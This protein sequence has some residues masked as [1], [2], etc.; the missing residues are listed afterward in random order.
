MSTL[1]IT[2]AR[3]LLERMRELVGSADSTLF[4]CSLTKRPVPVQ[5]LS[6]SYVETDGSIWF[7]TQG[8]L[9]VR[10]ED[11]HRAQLFYANTRD[12]VYL[13]VSGKG[14]VIPDREVVRQIMD[15]TGTITSKGI[16]QVL[17]CV[18][19]TSAFYWNARSGVV[20]PILRDRPYTN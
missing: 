14:Q 20:T 10:T 5:P 15:K 17:I 2:P 1:Q 13:S 18:V 4:T 6:V 8:K 19:P 7:F 11:P 9:L 12:M 16:D 3:E